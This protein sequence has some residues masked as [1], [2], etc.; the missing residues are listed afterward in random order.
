[1]VLIE[2]DRVVVKDRKDPQLNMKGK[3][4]FQMAGFLKIINHIANKIMKNN[5]DIIKQSRLIMSEDVGDIVDVAKV[6]YRDN[7]IIRVDIIN[8]NQDE[9]STHLNIT[10]NQH[11]ID[12]KIKRKEI[13]TIMIILMSHQEEED[14]EALQLNNITKNLILM[15]DLIEKD[16]NSIS[17]NVKS[18]TIMMK[19]SHLEQE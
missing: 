5:K 8:L 3:S 10:N 7:I 17:Q 14:S 4:A 19:G 13:T 6:K 12:I 9:N 11:I 15:N 16:A 1:V 18:S 2:T